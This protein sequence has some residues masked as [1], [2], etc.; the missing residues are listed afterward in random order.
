MKPPMHAIDL[1]RMDYGACLQMQRELVEARKQSE[2]P[3]TLLLVEHEPVITLGR[4]RTAAA[5]VVAAGDIPIVEVERGGDVTFH[6]PGQIV[7]YPIFRLEEHERDL[8]QG[9]R[10]DGDIAVSRQLGLEDGK[11][12]AG[13]RNAVCAFLDQPCSG[14]KKGIEYIDAALFDH[15]MRRRT[16]DD[17]V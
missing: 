7:G 2:I 1:G 13:R 6:G 9:A 16:W 14:L 3:D 8:H 4:R 15:S 10:R 5:N 17:S 12:A 11:I